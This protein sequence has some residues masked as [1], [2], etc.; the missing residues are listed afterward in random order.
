MHRRVVNGTNVDY[1]IINPRLHRAYARNVGLAPMD[2]YVSQIVLV[3]ASP[4]QALANFDKG[5]AW[6]LKYHCAFPFI[7]RREAAL[8]ATLDS[9]Y[10]FRPFQRDSSDTISSEDL[11]G[12][13]GYLCFGCF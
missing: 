8:F 6:V 10:A 12:F 4:G 1:V 7:A 13:D 11:M 9:C 2:H 5:F 3:Y